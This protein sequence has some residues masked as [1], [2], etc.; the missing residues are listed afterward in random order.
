M[1]TGSAMRKPRIHPG[2]GSAQADSM[3]D[4]RT[5][6]TGT[7]PLESVSACSPSALVNAYA[8]GHPTLAA[9]ERPAST[10]WSLTQRSRSCSVF[11]ARAGAPAAP[12]FVA[13][14][15]AILHQPFG[16]AAE[17]FCVAP[18]P[19]RGGNFRLPRQADV[20]RAGADEFFG[21]VAAPVAG[22]V[23]GADGDEVRG[24]AELLAQ[25]DDAHGA[26]Q[27]DLDRTVERRIERN[28]G[29]R[30]NDRV[31]SG[32][33]CRVGFVQARGRREIRRQRPW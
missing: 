20:E 1:M 30:V 33:E 24:D 31:G 13:C 8:S 7:L 5:I 21:C 22:D 9:R 2:F 10:S 29:S 12:E 27:V 4:G 32:P 18:Q 6:D 26:E 28:G 23:A 25:L 16:L 11:A 15:L 14:F 19:A 17:R 3:M